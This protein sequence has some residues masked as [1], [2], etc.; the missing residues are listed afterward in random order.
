MKG[1]DVNSLM[2]TLCISNRVAKGKKVRTFILESLC[3]SDPGFF[4]R[5]SFMVVLVR[6]AE[7]LEGNDMFPLD[8]G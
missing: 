8:R 1:N 6:K 7:V 5:N 4:K 2:N 3:C